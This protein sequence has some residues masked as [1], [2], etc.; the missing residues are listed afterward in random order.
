MKDPDP[1]GA[2]ADSGNPATVRST[3]A[4]ASV[5]ALAADNATRARSLRGAQIPQHVGMA[6]ACRALAVELPRALAVQI[7]DELRSGVLAQRWESVRA[8]AAEPG[9]SGEFDSTLFAIALLL[10]EQGRTAM[11]HLVRREKEWTAAAY[12]LEGQASALEGSAAQLLR[13]ATDAEGHDVGGAGASAEASASTDNR[14]AATAR[15]VTE[16]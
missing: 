13:V 4:V 3:D 9:A 1:T 11:R 14:G 16:R 10:R 7:D 8:A 15:D 6:A 2:T 5:R 12:R